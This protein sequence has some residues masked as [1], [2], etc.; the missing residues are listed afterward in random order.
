VGDQVLCRQAGDDDD[1]VAST[2]CSS[3]E[4][5]DKCVF[6]TYSGADGRH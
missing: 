4:R 2:H 3:Q 5:G 1:I 6:R